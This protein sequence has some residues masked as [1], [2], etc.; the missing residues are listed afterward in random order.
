MFSKPQ[1]PLCLCS[2]IKLEYVPK[3]LR[4]VFS[5]LVCLFVFRI[6]GHILKCLIVHYLNALVKMKDVNPGS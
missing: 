3:N 4:F 5:L 6:L 2:F 1:E